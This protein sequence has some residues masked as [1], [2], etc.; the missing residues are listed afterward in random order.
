[1]IHRF[2]AGVLHIFRSCSSRSLSFI[3]RASSEPH[4]CLVHLTGPKLGGICTRVLRW[5]IMCT[6]PSIFAAPLA[7]ALQLHGRQLRPL[8]G[9]HRKSSQFSMS[10]GR[11]RLCECCVKITFWKR[12]NPI[13]IAISI[14]EIGASAVRG[15]GT[16]P[17]STFPSLSLISHYSSHP[18]GEHTFRIFG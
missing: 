2:D 3:L 11:V 10:S 15:E 8:A 4:L 7:R 6:I 12:I 18:A 14:G 1:M 13:S 16:P 17:Y 9:I 5:P